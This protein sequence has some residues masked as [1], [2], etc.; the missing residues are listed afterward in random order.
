LRIGQRLRR[1]PDAVGLGLQAR[2]GA[3]VTRVGRIRQ[4]LIL[5]EAQ[6]QIQRPL[7]ALDY[8]TLNFLNYR[9]SGGTPLNCF[10]MH[11]LFGLAPGSS[12]LAPAP[13]HPARNLRAPAGVE[14]W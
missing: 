5:R 3:G 2:I 9:N 10:S 6:R 4:R 14:S 13:S 12:H 8:A 1:L 7:G 11:Q